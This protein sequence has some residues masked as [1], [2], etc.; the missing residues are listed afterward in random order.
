MKYSISSPW[1]SLCNREG[2]VLSHLSYPSTWLCFDRQNQLKSLFGNSVHLHY[3]PFLS[4]LSIQSVISTNC[5][6]LWLQR[7]KAIERKER[8]RERTGYFVK[9]KKKKSRRP[10]MECERLCVGLRGPRDSPYFLALEGLC[11]AASSPYCLKGQ[12]KQGQRKQPWGKD[13]LRMRS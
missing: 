9:K 3:C 13:G 8:E 11:T 5:I 4:P 1:A 7:N 12:N 6:I 10:I 2:S